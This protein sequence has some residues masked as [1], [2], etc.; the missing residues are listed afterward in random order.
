M[1][2]VAILALASFAGS[3]AD[4]LKS[5]PA[6]QRMSQRSSSAKPFVRRGRL[7]R[8]NWA[9]KPNGGYIP[10]VKGRRDASLKSRSNRR[11]ASR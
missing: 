1:L 9:S 8:V 7:D 5:A 4:L 11:K 3:S 2:P 6:P 10:R